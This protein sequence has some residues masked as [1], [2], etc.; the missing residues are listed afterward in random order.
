VMDANRKIAGT[1]RCNKQDISTVR[2]QKFDNSVALEDAIFWATL[3]LVEQMD[4][5]HDGVAYD[6]QA[7]GA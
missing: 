3:A 7:F 4:G 2:S 1:I 6:L 5:F